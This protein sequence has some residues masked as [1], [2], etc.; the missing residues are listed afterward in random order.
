MKDTL[1]SINDFPALPQDEDGPV[2]NQPWEAKAFAL[3]VRLSEAGHFTW[4][5]WVRIFSQ[6]SMD[7]PFLF[8]QSRILQPCCLTAHKN[9]C[10]L[11]FSI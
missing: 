6:K 5:E 1:L 2:F 8:A 10:R 3:A 11:H 4:P 9:S 7:L